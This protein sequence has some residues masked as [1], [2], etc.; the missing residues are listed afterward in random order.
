MKKI[1]FIILSLFLSSGCET[2]GRLMNTHTGYGNYKD[3]DWN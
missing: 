3:N 2:T 1:T